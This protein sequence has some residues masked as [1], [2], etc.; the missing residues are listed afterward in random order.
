MFLNE[1]Q[2]KELTNKHQSAAQARQLDFMGI[3]YKKRGDG[4]IA[5]LQSHIDKLFGGEHSG[6]LKLVKTSEPNWTALE[7]AQAA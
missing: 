6:N 5:V 1:S 4:S 2:L 7:N 3:E